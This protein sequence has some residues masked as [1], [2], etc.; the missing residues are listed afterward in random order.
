[1]ALD[2]VK[3]FERIRHDLLLQEAIKHEYPL[4]LL[5]LSLLVYRMQRVLRIDGFISERL[6]G[7]RGIT[8]GSGFANTEMF[9]S[10]L[11]IVDRLTAGR[12]TLKATL[13][14]DDLALEAVGG[15][16]RMTQTLIDAGGSV[17]SPMA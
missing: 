10:M 9:L 6:V 13:Y 4:W 5:R 15:S 8:A 7:T 1:M 2:L 11:S 12:P 16:A 14:I 3:A 17:C